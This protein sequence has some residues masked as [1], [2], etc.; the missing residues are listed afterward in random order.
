MFVKPT[1][2]EPV[3]SRFNIP[4]AGDAYFEVETRLPAQELIECSRIR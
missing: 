1:P 3:V 2:D 4:P